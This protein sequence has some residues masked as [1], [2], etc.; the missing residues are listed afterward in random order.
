MLLLECGQLFSKKSINLDR[1][2]DRTNFPCN[3]FLGFTLFCLS[4]RKVQHLN[5]SHPNRKSASSSQN[6]ARTFA[7]NYWASPVLPS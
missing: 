7:S 1:L 4:L 6:E 5:Q 2:I 3:A